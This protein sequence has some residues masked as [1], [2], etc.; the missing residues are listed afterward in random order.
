MTSDN[1]GYSEEFLDDQE[2]LERHRSGDSAAFGLLFNKHRDRAYHY[3]FKYVNSEDRADDLVLEAFT[4][5]LETI[6]RGKGPTVSMGHYLASTIRNIAITNGAND[7]AE[8]PSDPHELAERYEREQF[9]DSG[10]T[11][12]WLA[13]AFNTLSARS[14]RVLWFRAIENLPSQQ[15]AKEIGVSTSSASRIYQEAASELREHFVDVSVNASPDPAC[16]EFA[17]LLREMAEQK[18]RVRGKDL[19]QKLQDHLNSC[20]YC[21]IVATRLGASDRVLLSLIFLAGLGAL[22]ADAL[23][24][25]PASAAT[26]LPVA[27]KVALVA[28]PIISVAVIVGALFMP[29]SSGDASVILG[30]S[31]SESSNTLLRV[32]DCELAREPLDER[33]EAWRLSTEAKDCD[34]HIDYLGDEDRGRS[35]NATFMDTAQDS[36]LRTREVNR[37]GQ[38]AVTLTDGSKTV[39]ATITVRA[40]D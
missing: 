22:A 3:A 24:S 21:S 18:R 11:A 23:R 13:E 14:Q 9:E 36:E 20:P 17:P 15:V 31:G 33:T 27:L 5:I 1:Q 4:R 16:R 39:K 26:M 35:T 19:N 28:V 37:P 10:S 30:E 34:V 40:R 29:A 25:T 8:T 7:R 6:R 12:G 2:L 32:G 38:Y